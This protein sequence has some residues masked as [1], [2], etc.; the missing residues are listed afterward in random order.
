MAKD[1]TQKCLLQLKPDL[2]KID[3]KFLLKLMIS[4]RKKELEVIEKIYER[5]IVKYKR[6]IYERNEKRKAKTV[7]VHLKI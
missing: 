7:A 2:K 3:K 5:D 4:K 6:K 1:Q